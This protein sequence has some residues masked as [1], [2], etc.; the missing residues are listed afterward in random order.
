MSPET[1]RLGE[2]ASFIRGITFKPGDVVPLG[3]DGSVWCLR[4]KNVQA[5]LDL[6]DVWAIDSGFVK[7]GEQYLQAG[8]LLVSSAN[9]WNLIGKCS[10]VPRLE[11]DATFGG[12]VTVL[13]GNPQ[14][15]DRR[16]LYH[17]FSS[18]RTQAVVRSFSRQTTNI[19]NLD[20]RR[21]SELAIPLPPLAQQKRIAAVL[22]QVDTLRAK[23]REAIALLDDLVQSTFFEMFGDPVSN[24]CGWERVRMGDLLV[25][26]ESGKS[27]Q[28]LDRQAKEGEWGVLKLGAITQCVYLQDETKALPSAVVPDARHEVR[29][30]DL[31]FSRK[32]TPNL[33]AASAYVRSTRS[34]LLMPDLI[35]RLVVADNAL[36]DKVYLHAL[37]TQSGKRRKLQELA[38]GSAASMVNISK[39]KLLEFVCEVPPLDLQR[40]F[41]Q[42]IEAIEV[43][44]D[45]CR[46][47]LAT[48]DE[49]FTS[50]Q[51]RAFSG[52]LWDHEVTGEAA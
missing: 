2:V 4:T 28:C 22:D 40:K 5:E 1:A 33:V 6:S 26:I 27:P 30:G 47:H 34:R 20:L 46:N 18:S 9:S 3:A 8:D 17:W 36:I 51:H 25:G 14:F 45:V 50:L 43:Q 42:F 32:N 39:S 16:Y 49:L 52:T 7:R 38:A 37:L 48:L 35:F 11:S 10:W 29:S 31:L 44:R 13:R 23:R 19:A 24:N 12:F 15:V 21:C 41:A